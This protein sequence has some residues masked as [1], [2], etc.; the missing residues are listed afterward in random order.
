MNKRTVLLLGV[1]LSEEIGQPLA[2][3]H[4][5]EIEESGL[6]IISGEDSDKYY[7]GKVLAQ[8][9]PYKDSRHIEI[10]WN[11]VD[12]KAI[13]NVRQAIF[14]TCNLTFAFADIKLWFFD[15]WG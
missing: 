7:L 4:Y 5:E 11:I 13:D 12:T 9:S 8:S 14:D 15:W 6:D 10:D 3:D 2:W 1:Q